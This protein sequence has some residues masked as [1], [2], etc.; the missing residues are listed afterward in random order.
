MVFPLC[1]VR[2]PYG[3]SRLLAKARKLPFFDFPLLAIL[4]IGECWWALNS[5]EGVWASY[6]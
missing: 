4:R 5:D 1:F 2:W 6:W 3:F